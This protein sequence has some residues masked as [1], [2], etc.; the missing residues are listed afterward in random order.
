L[1]L[2]VIS[3]WPARRRIQRVPTT[4]GPPTASA[5]LSLVMPVA[6][7]SQNRRSISHR[8]DGAP[9][10]RIAPR[11]VNLCIHPAG[12]PINTSI[13]EVLRRPVE[14]ALRPAV[15]VMHETASLQGS[16]VMQSLLQCVQDE[17]GMGGS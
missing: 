3:G 6:I 12:R 13:I 11:P 9:G 5:A 1:D 17:A 15:R 16:S 10:E 4:C 14:Y 2:V 8:S 7:C